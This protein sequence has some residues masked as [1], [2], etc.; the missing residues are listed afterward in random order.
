M[1]SAI[2][3]SNI[4]IYLE[5]SRSSSAVGYIPPLFLTPQFGYV[6]Q[7]LNRG[8]PE[9]RDISDKRPSQ[10]GTFDFTEFFGARAI[11]FE[12]SLATELQDIPSITDE[13]LEDNL[14]K[15]MLP[16]VRAYLYVKPKGETLYRR[17]LVRPANVGSQLN[18]VTNAGFRTVSMSW[19]GVDGVFEDAELSSTNLEV[20]SAVEAGR[21]YDQAYDKTYAASSVIG[22][23]IVRNAGNAPSFPVVYVYGACT[24]PRIE[25]VTTGKKLEFLAAYTINAGEYLVIDFAEGTV[26]LN[27]DS[28]NSRYDKIDFAGGISDWWDLQ[29][30]DNLLRF[31]PLSSSPPSTARIEWRSKFI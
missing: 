23:K 5:D 18:F 31:Y 13:I 10:N 30:G 16:N 14:R 2:T 12:V 8:F 20:S 1:T 19:R 28:T 24:Q 4:D 11:T 22:A 7:R 25:N 26:Y 6:P 27:G 3:L 9:I 29:P 15:W 21:T 17:A